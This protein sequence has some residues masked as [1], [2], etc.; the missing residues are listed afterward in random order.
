MAADQPTFFIN[1]LDMDFNEFSVPH[2]PSAGSFNTDSAEEYGAAGFE[3][4]P[5]NDADCDYPQ[6]DF[7]QSPFFKHP[8]Y[9]S[10]K[11]PSST[12]AP[13]SYLAVDNLDVDWAWDKSISSSSYT[14]S[15]QRTE[16][17]VTES[18]YFGDAERCQQSLPNSAKSSATSQSDKK[19]GIVSSD[20]PSKRNCSEAVGT[21]PE[22][23]MRC[24]RE[25]TIPSKSSTK[26]K[27]EG[28]AKARKSG[29]KTSPT[30]PT[31][32]SQSSSG[33]KHKVQLRTSAR[34]PKEA[35]DN[36]SSSPT[37]PKDRDEG[38]IQGT[39]EL[40][41]RQCH[42]LVEKQ[43]RN[44]L[45]RQFENLL[46]VLPVDGECTSAS[47]SG[48]KTKTSVTD[49]GGAAAGVEGGER[50]LSKA[51]VLDMARQRIVTLEREYDSL[52]SERM[53]LH[54]NAVVVGDAVR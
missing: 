52:Q 31:T 34:K 36:S 32:S 20:R 10:H 11:L 45:N 8:S 47:A 53:G 42:N 24:K 13:A 9:N 27:P 44:R 46:A 40:Q 29:D 50:R 43:Y 33:G 35:A 3:F 6:L 2:L 25:A 38:I 37:A 12:A 18:S 21:E 49:R 51:E 1:E 15:R 16:S 7:P 23:P 14:Y 4:M 5:W 41:A 28:K 54:P 48:R 19:R 30:S 17:P 22:P 39:D 26:S